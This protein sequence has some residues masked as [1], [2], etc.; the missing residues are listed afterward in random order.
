ML[1]YQA[2]GVNGYLGAH[3]QV[4]DGSGRFREYIGLTIGH[5]S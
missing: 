5:E 4:W 2:T 1:G 3:Y